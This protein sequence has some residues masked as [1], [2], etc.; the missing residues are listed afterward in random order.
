MKVRAR[1]R[2]TLNKLNKS[3]TKFVRLGYDTYGES[4]KNRAFFTKL[5]Y[6]R[7]K[8]CRCSCG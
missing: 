6:R 8:K 4:I 7:P 2:D 1:N 5:T 3:W